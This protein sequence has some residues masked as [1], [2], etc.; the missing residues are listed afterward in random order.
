MTS[1]EKQWTPADAERVERQLS[2]GGYQTVRFRQG[3]GGTLYAVLIEPI[4]TVKDAQVL[5][6]TLREQG[7]A[8]AVVLAGSDPLVVRVGDPVPLRGAVQL[9]ERLRAKGHTIRLAAQ[10]GDVIA[11]VVRHGNFASRSE[12]EGQAE[13]IGR[14]GLGSH[15]VQ[16]R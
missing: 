12:A 4:A 13:D 10:P 6:A 7:F 3:I 5:V 16:V 8:D 9:G 2:E 14:L 11:I 1:E 15:V